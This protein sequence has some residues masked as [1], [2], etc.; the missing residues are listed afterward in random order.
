VTKEDELRALLGGN[1]WFMDVLAAVRA[2]GPPNW[3]VGAGVIRNI[4]W[5]YLQGHDT[6]TP[7]KDVD[8]AFFD[9]SDATRERDAALERQL[10]AAMSSVPWEVTNQ[11]SIHFWY[12]ARFGY[13]IRPA[14]SIEDAVSMWPETATSVAAT[15]DADGRIRVIA[16]VGLDDSSRCAFAAT[17]V[18]SRGKHSPSASARRTPRDDGHWWRSCASERVGSLR[19]PGLAERGARVE[20]VTARR[21]M[22]RLANSPTATAAISASS[23]FVAQGFGSSG[24]VSE[25]TQ[26]NVYFSARRPSSTEASFR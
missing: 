5:D 18:R 8:V 11:A 10:Y 9:P 7:V 14:D 26:D 15:L 21:L 4:V 2:C 6:P 23:P 25:R 22:K 1:R 13:P 17:R 20:A 19:H 3:V 24:E 16:L 12:E